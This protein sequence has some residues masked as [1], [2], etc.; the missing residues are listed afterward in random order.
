MPDSEL[1]AGNGDFRVGFPS[2]VIETGTA[3]RCESQRG[4][5][6]E[7]CGIIVRR[8][9]RDDGRQCYDKQDSLEAIG[10]T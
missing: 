7:S 1:L 2:T 3:R 8:R 10:T 5:C 4:C 9:P 6:D